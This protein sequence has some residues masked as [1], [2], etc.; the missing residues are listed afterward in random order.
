LIAAM[1]LWRAI[2]AGG[3]ETIAGYTLAQMLSY[4]LIVTLVE[5]TTAVTEDEW[6]IATD[7]KD[8]QISQFLVRPVDY[9]H[10]RLCLFSANRL[11]YTAVAFLPMT[12]IVFW[13][14]QYLL[15]PANVAACL[16]FICALAL[17]ALLQFLLAYLTALMA[18]WV[19]EISTL[20]FML[21][22]AQ[23]L[24]SGEMFPLDLLPGW[25]NQALMLT[26]FP[27]CMFFP[28]SVYMG[29]VAGPE[30]VNGLLMQGM[31]VVVLFAIS[32]L[33]WYRGLRTYTAVGG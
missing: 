28:V 8:G 19:L 25:L 33:V 15:P 12:A 13:N 6:Q 20:S 4:Y 29:R 23:R 17:S 18:F 3:K 11:I 27:Y 1:A 14:L 5:T 22:A 32:R 10:Y 9:L 21:L 31:W 2:F 26:P 16:G 24:A 7:I 30:L